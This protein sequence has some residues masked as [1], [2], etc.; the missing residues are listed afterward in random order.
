[1]PSE[2]YNLLRILVCHSYFLRFDEKQQQ[3]G[4]PYPPLATLQVAALLRQAGHNV[5]LFD[6][7]LANGIEDYESKLRAS[8][9]EVVLFY[10]DNHNYL[11]KMCLGRMRRASCDMIATAHSAG[12]RVIS[13]GSDP[14]DA[15]ET[16]LSA[17][18]DAVLLGEGLA[19]LIAII[20]RLNNELRMPVAQLI[21]GLPGVAATDDD[22]IVKSR[23]VAPLPTPNLAA[24]PA[25]DLIDIDAYRGI[26]QNAQGYFSLNMAASRGCSFRCNWCAKPIWGDRYLQRE[27]SDVATEM[28]YLKQEFDID[29]VWFADDI[30][31]FRA[32]WVDEF[33][34][35]LEADGGGVPFTIQS[36]ADLIRPPMA[37]ALHR[38]GCREV[39]I[40]AESGSQKILDAMNKGTCIPEILH[41]RE[42]LGSHGVRVGFF[43]MLGYLGEEL[44]DILATRDLVDRAGPD[45]VGVS[46]AYPLPGTQFYETVKRQLGWKKN[47]DDSNDLDV[48]F[49]GTYRSE[50]YRSVRDLL[51]DQVSEGQSAELQAR[52]TALVEREAQYRSAP[53][54]PSNARVAIA[55]VT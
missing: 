6:A 33:A 2:V 38:A 32:D 42:L 8:Q 40:G 50:F 45:D 21:A 26:W 29:H 43:L 28:L 49:S 23:A 11:S 44:E 54:A 35:A 30:F 1:M 20:D 19:A 15:P 46:V 17:G 16:Y 51:H 18:A 25:W 12:A 10:E 36:R 41:A 37:E 39:W 27:A 52:W 47:W 34:T 48:M 14:S 7:M 3:R 24:R 13:A 4:K 55:S 9:P 53:S 31:G 5:G 22:S